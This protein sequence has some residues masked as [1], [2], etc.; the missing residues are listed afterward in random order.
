MGRRFNAFIS[1]VFPPVRDKDSVIT[2]CAACHARVLPV[3][4]DRSLGS[5]PATG[6]VGGAAPWGSSVTSAPTRSLVRSLRAAVRTCVMYASIQP[7]G[8][9]LK[10]SA[11]ASQ[12]PAPVALA[13]QL[14]HFMIT[15]SARKPIF[16]SD[17]AVVGSR[18][19]PAF[20][21]QS[22][23][24]RP[25]EVPAGRRQPDR[26]THACAPI[27]DAPGTASAC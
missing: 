13:C 12:L 6:T 10:A 8:S 20:N 24:S 15:P 27:P 14:P 18:V 19:S 4:G 3:A 16:N 21:L 17:R 1:N 2:L 22:E 26:R 7:G 5:G 23:T 11:V 25:P 9:G